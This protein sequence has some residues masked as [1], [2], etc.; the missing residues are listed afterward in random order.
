MNATWNIIDT[1]T[2]WKNNKPKI[3]CQEPYQITKQYILMKL[4]AFIEGSYSCAVL[5][6]SL[7]IWLSR[8]EF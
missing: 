5:T 1:E 8:H 2:G 4:K 7:S 6:Y 3:V